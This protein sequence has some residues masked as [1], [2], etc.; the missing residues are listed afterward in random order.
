MSTG[1]DPTRLNQ[2]I[3]L[4]TQVRRAHDDDGEAGRAAR[5]ALLERYR[6]AAHRYLLGVLRD[7]AAAEDLGQEFAYRFLHGDL[8]G[9]DPGRGRFRDYVKGVLFHL[10]ADHHHKQK[11][12]PRPLGDDLPEPAQECPLAAEREE[13]FR[14]SW[15]DEL[16][17]RTWVALQ[18]EQDAGGPP[19]H[20]VL[21]F[22]VDH[23]DLPSHA[24]AGPLSETLG[25]P[26]TAA[27]VRKSLE[28]ARD[29]FA[30]LLLDLIAQTLDP[31]TRDR[32]EDELAALD[33]LEHCKSALERRLA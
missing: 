15:R 11:R 27:G 26:L 13:A 10:V 7:P 31:P 29:R 23:P 14:T 25:K 20:A 16:F 28:R 33:L 17:S 6:G 12:A 24:M 9:V 30:D 3:T 32:L 19:Y 5:I 22:R 8:R 18:A 1:D 4:W 21:R 2:I